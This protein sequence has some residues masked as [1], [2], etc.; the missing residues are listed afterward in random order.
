[1]IV[2]DANV[3]LR[4]LTAS[5]DPRVR[6][7][8]DIAKALFRQVARGDVEVTTSDA[9]LAEAAYILTEKAHSHVP[10]AEAAAKIAALV[11]LPGFRLPDKRSVVLALE[12]W[13]SFPRLG[14]VDALVAVHAQQPGVQLAAF[15]SDFD[16]LPGIDRWRPGGTS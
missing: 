10:V 8:N 3:I 12:L 9:V 16:R 2:V 7:A 15:D 4:A 14:F 13:V 5:D 11:S 6:R 1:M